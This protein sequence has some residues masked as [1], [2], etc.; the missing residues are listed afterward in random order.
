MKDETRNRYYQDAASWALNARAEQLNSLRR[1]RILAGALAL[2]ALLEAFALVLLI[3]LK[4]VSMVPVLVDRQTGYVQRLNPDGSQDLRANDALVRSML[5]QYVA[6]RESFSIGAVAG[7]YRKVA[8]WSGGPA[9]R[10][11]LALMPAS[12]PQSP[13]RLY[14]RTTL[15]ETWIK[16]VSP[17]GPGSA[18]V[19]FETRRRDQGAS[20]SSV[21][22]WAAVIGYRFSNAALSVADR[23][24]NPLGFQVVSY[25]RDPEVPP[26]IEPTPVSA[27]AAPAQAV[28]SQP[29]V[30]RAS[31]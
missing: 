8:L 27:S 2:V 13:L 9:R 6:A 3:P 22:D 15:I 10:D 14:P 25:R 28:A 4:T 30:T 1:T 31:P 24:T 21:Q 11:Y 16:S 26:A 20:P 5:A 19:R 12:N 7:D 17:T 18:L 29:P 23:W